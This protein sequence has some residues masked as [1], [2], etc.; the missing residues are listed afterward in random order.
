MSALA[1][2]GFLAFGLLA[3]GVHFA[4]LRWNAALY[5]RR[6]RLGW[7]LVLHVLRLAGT[8]A[9]LV[10]VARLGAMPLLLAAAGIVI[11][12]PIVVRHLGGASS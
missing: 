4:L 10:V 9:L 1:A 12:R 8:A 5:G 7:A 2:A 3:G 11:A 6:E